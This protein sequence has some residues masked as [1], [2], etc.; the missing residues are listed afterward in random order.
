MKIFL[1]IIIPVYNKFKELEALLQSIVKYGIKIPYEIIVVIDN[2]SLK[3]NLDFINN[4]NINIIQNNLKKGAGYSR[5][6]GVLNS[7]GDI[8][9]FLDSDTLITE[10]LINEMIDEYNIENGKAAIC[11]DFKKFPVNYNFFTKFLSLKWYYSTTELYLKNNRRVIMCAFGGGPSMI[12]KIIYFQSGGYDFNFH[13]YKS[14]GGEEFEA[15]LNIMKIAPI[16]YY[17]KFNVSHNYRTVFKAFNLTIKRSFNYAMILFNASE[18]EKKIMKNLV[19]INDKTN[20]IILL[21]FYINILL[22]FLSKSN[23][24]LIGM[25]FFLGAYIFFDFKF[26]RFIKNECGLS[27]IIPAILQSIILLSAKG[28]GVFLAVVNYYILKNKNLRF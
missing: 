23:I 19:S 24:Y 5:H 6:L 4:Y 28:T 10:N 22:L 1:S 11:G 27:Y 13:H 26:L 15:A 7:N 17:E 2:N 18:D 20:L 16:Y 14:C 25:I 21:L 9:L 12:S 3:I 8:L